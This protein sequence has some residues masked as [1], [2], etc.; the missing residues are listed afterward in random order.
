MEEQQ[1]FYTYLVNG[2]EKFTSNY[3]LA[4]KRADENTEIKIII[5]KLF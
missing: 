3:D 1:E 2:K 4:W 5:R